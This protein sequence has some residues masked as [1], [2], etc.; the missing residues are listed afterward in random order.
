MA[1]D[2]YRVILKGY[3]PGKGEYYIEEGFA[4]L[5][6]IP[7]EKAREL[8]TGAPVTIKENITKSQAEKYQLAIKNV[9]ATCEI[10]NMKFDLGGLSL[11]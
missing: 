10:E 8:F 3:G 11:E 9:G 2:L 5:F 1:E 4:G 6:K 7:R